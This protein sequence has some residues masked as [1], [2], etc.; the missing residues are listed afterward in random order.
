MLTDISH[1]ARVYNEL[2]PKLKAL[3]SSKFSFWNMFEKFVATLFIKGF[4]VLIFSV[5]PLWLNYSLATVIPWKAINLTTK[6]NT[7]STGPSNDMYGF[8]AAY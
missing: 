6:G 7:S 2:F 8:F 4:F 5:M 1:N 3:Y